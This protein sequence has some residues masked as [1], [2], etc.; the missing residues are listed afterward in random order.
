MGFSYQFGTNP[1]VDWPRILIADTQE[2][3]HVFEDEEI[4]SVYAIA[5][6]AWQSSMKYSGTQGATLPSTPASPYRIAAILLKSLAGNRARLSS[7]TQLLDV[8]K[9]SPAV[10]AKA[11][12]D[13]ANDWLKM[14]DESGAFVLIE[15]C[16]TTWSFKDRFWKQV[17][18]QLGA[19]T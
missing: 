5:G 7:V 13:Q 11:L 9:I 3:K 16:N 2:C 10:A 15:Q 8:K 14:D 18:R 17:Q 1:Q 19:V 4:L 6:A 12:M